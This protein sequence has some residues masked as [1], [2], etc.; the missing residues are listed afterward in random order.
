MKIAYPDYW[1]FFSR[2][3]EGKMTGIFYEITAT[4]LH[5][6]M[7][8]KL[9]W[10]KYP[11]KR[12]QLNV[13]RGIADA[14]ITVPTKKRLEYC[15]TH[16]KPLYIKKMNIFTY[17]D[18]PD[19][20]K[21]FDIKSVDD[22]K[23][24]GLAVITYAGNGWNDEKI[25]A[26]GIKTIEAHPR[27]AEWNMLAHRRGDI[28][29]EWPAGAWPDIVK[30]GQQNRIIQTDVVIDKMPFHLLINKRSPYASRL[31]E[32]SEVVEEMHKNGTINWILQKYRYTID[33]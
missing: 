28:V 19:L 10:N 33:D 6:Q 26:R 32:F 3:A 17:A 8:I 25:K 7:G 21:I 2:T 16:Q 29:I 4:A 14:M 23:A 30:A 12:C 5:D 20:N 24:A 11:W 27:S 15:F 1:P 18:H 22:V 31:D 13:E 9:Q